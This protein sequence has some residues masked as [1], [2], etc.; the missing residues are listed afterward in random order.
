MGPLTITTSNMMDTVVDRAIEDAN[1]ADQKSFIRDENGRVLTD[2][3]AN[4]FAEKL[5]NSELDLASNLS[6]S[7]EMETEE[8][9]PMRDRKD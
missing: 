2:N 9:E 8:K 4:L 6:S 5:E 3:N 1:R 7:T